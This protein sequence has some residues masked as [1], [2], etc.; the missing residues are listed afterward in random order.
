MHL[1]RDVIMYS[2]VNFKD[3]KHMRDLCSM[4]NDIVS[5]LKKGS[6]PCY[7]HKNKTH[8]IR[9]GISMYH[10]EA[11]ETTKSWVMAGKPRQGHVLK[12]KKLTNARYK[13]AIRFICKK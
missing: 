6:K 4:Y 9:S 13:Y 7:K 12:Y 10:A 1:P 2:Y 8:N 3:V 11:C 5:S